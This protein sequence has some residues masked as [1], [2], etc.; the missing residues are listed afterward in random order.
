M[1]RGVQGSTWSIHPGL[2]CGRG[3]AG[4]IHEVGDRTLA[5]EC[6]LDYRACEVWAIG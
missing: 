6:N 4:E 5:P 2:G 3:G 1:D